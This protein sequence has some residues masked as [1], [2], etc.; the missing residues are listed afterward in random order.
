[1]GTLDLNKVPVHSG[2]ITETLTPY[3]VWKVVDKAL[4]AEGL[5]TIPSQMVYTYVQNRLIPA[6]KVKNDE[7]GFQIRVTK[8]A[9]AAWVKKYV[10]RR[11]ERAAE[12]TATA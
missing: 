7:G 10:G 1:M 9:A 11:K 8:T 5:D 3:G 6:V 4:K 2:A 12:E